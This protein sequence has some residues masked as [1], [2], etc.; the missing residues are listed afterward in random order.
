VS[1]EDQAAE[2]DFFAQDDHPPM[3]DKVVAPSGP[4]PQPGKPSSGNL[5]LPDWMRDENGG[6][7][8]AGGSMPQPSDDFEEGGRSKL[9]L[10]AGLGVLVVGLVAAGGVYLVKGRGGSDHT[11]HAAVPSRP[12][13]TSPKSGSANSQPEKALAQF[14]GDHRR[15]PWPSSASVRASS[16]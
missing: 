14:K 4:P 7:G 2:N 8:G 6:T 16:P 10:F 12:A 15:A 5:R 3:W 13:K 1:A 9:P 11:A